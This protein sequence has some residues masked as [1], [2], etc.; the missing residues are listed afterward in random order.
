MN[1]I[2]YPFME[3]KKKL[4]EQGINIDKLLITSPHGALWGEG[5]M[6]VVRQIWRDERL[7]VVLAYERYGRKK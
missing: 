2:G 4:K 1:I 6:R 3:A 7:E 5:N